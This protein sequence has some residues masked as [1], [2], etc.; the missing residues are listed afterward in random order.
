VQVPAVGR[1]AVTIPSTVGTPPLRVPLAAELGRP[2]VSVLGTSGPSPLGWIGPAPASTAVP[3]SPAPST[4]AA[5]AFSIPGHVIQDGQ[6]TFATLTASSTLTFPLRREWPL[7]VDLPNRRVEPLS[8]SPEPEWDVL[9]GLGLIDAVS[10]KRAME[11]IELSFTEPLLAL[12]AAYV[13]W[14]AGEFG[15]LRRSGFEALPL[16]ATLDQTVLVLAIYDHLGDPPSLQPADSSQRL[17]FPEMIAAQLEPWAYRKEV[18][19]LRW[20]LGL[21]LSLLDRVPKGVHFDLWRSTLLAVE[22]GLSGTSTW[23]AHTPQPY[24]WLDKSFVKPASH[25]V[26][27]PWLFDPTPAGDM[28]QYPSDHAT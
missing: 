14:S 26:E 2:D 4:A 1:A 11:L 12:A 15:A 22:A 10:P 13:L 7:A 16:P 20:G 17:L 27:F 21:T 24:L 8:A 6:A 5:W 28:V 9:V 25:D 18:P 19:L 3:L 23:T